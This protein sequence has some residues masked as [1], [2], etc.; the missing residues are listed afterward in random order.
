MSHHPG[1]SASVVL[2]TIPLSW[3]AHSS[4]FPPL[5]CLPVHILPIRRPVPGRLQKALSAVPPFSSPQLG[6]FPAWDL[7]MGFYH[8]GQAGLEL[9][10]SGDLARLGLPKFWDYRCE[11]QCPALFHFRHQ[12]APLHRAPMSM[13]EYSGAIT[14]H[15]RLELLGSMMRSYYVAKAGLE[16]PNSSNLPSSAYQSAGITALQTVIAPISLLY[17]TSRNS[18]R[19]D[20]G[21]D[22]SRKAVAITRIKRHTLGGRGRQIMRSQEIKTILA[23]M[24]RGFTVLARLVLNPWLKSSACLSLPKSEV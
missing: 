4:D 8:V 24:R 20:K 2:L 12:P 17:G 18:F 23:N 3:N 22:G 11:S 14:D 21:F 13:L 15:C 16:L 7:W 10:N 19:E 1:S 6:A 9:L 5:L